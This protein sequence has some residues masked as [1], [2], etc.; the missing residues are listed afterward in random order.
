M[1]SGA[2]PFYLRLHKIYPND[3]FRDLLHYFDLNL[4]NYT[5]KWAGYNSTKYLI[6]LYEIMETKC[7][8][9]QTHEG[10]SETSIIETLENFFK[11]NT[12]FSP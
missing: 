9:L 4:T 6:E 5:V 10:L 7:E 12:K 11:T 8:I 1:K 2:V 3:V